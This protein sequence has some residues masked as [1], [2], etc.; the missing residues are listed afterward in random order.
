MVVRVGSHV[1]RKNSNIHPLRPL[2]P[3]QSEVGE[4][5]TIVTSFVCDALDV[6]DSS[7][8]RTSAEYSPPATLIRQYTHHALERLQ[9]RRS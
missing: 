1:Q 6:Y 2:R 8:P 9:V 3:P 7:S 5:V 4:R